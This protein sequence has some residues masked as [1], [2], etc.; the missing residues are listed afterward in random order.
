VLPPTVKR[1]NRF[2]RKRP[3]PPGECFEKIRSDS[4]FSPF[5]KKGICLLLKADTFLVSFLKSRTDRFPLYTCSGRLLP[6]LRLPAG[7][8]LPW[9]AGSPLHLS[10][11]LSW[12]SLSRRQ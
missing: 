1:R 6:S 3:R 2:P 7:I 11:F 8:I 5:L 4:Y 12:T 9:H 10:H